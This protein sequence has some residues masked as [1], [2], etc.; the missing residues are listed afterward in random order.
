MD[1]FID[2][3][4]KEVM[5]VLIFVNIPSPSLPTEKSSLISSP[6][7][8]L[9]H[10]PRYATTCTLWIIPQSSILT[11]SPTQLRPISSPPLI[12]IT[13]ILRLWTSFSLY[14]KPCWRSFA[15]VYQDILPPGKA[16]S[17]RTPRSWSQ[18]SMSYCSHHAWVCKLLLI[19]CVLLI[20]RLSRI[21]Y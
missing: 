15:S 6:W 11:F 20:R 17:M 16:C 13:A 19:T 12:Q 1:S 8:F 7:R 5:V 10:R 3:P 4:C 21:S 9:R 18:I 14:L 2:W